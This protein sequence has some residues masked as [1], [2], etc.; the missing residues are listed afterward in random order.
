M[1]ELTKNLL[2]EFQRDFPLVA[3]P[4]AVISE[5]MGVSEDDVIE[6]LKGLRAQGILSRVGAVF[7]TGTIGHSTLAAMSVPPGRL[8]E[9]AALVSS[10]EAVNH[11]Y[12]REHRLNLW[13]VVTAPDTGSVD[14]VILEIERLTEIK[15]LNLPMLDDYHLDLGFQ[16]QWN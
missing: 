1:N 3:R 11:N 5:R 8:E 6:A 4:Y 7:K 12:E 13:F 14:G 2:D 10:F 15:V 9:I 16:L